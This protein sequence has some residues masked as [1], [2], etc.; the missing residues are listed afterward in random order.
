MTALLLQLFWTFFVIGIFNFGGGGSMISIIQAQ[1][2]AQKHWIT[3][4]TFANIV[5]ISQTT[6]G[7][8]GVNTATYVGYEVMNDA[9]YPDFV[10]V[11]G[12]ASCT[13]AIVLPSFIIFF[14]LMK[15]Y[16]KYHGGRVFSS[17]MSTLRP[18]TAGLI[19]AAA[20]VL[21]FRV[22]MD[23]GLHVAVIEENFPD[24]KSWALAAAAFS[25]AM[26]TRVSP[27]AIILCAGVAGLLI[28]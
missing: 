1:V 18:A 22:S 27:I 25:L 2:V 12:S 4:E 14:L 8:I 7:P 11:L 24:W 15:L 16:S 13:F 9:G 26:W 21:M 20:F 17:V 10:S 23:S 6:P 3:E 5:A 28:Y 19:G